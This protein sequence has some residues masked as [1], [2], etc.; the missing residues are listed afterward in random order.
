[1]NHNIYMDYNATAPVLAQA[2]DAVMRAL[3]FVGNPSSVHRMGRLAHRLVED[4]RESVRALVNANGEARVVFTSG[5]TEANAICLLGCGRS[6]IIAS[7]I[8][9]S[10]VRNVKENIELI[11]VDE[12]GIVDI[13]HLE[14]L[15]S[16][17]GE[18]TIVS[19]MLANNETGAI[20]PVKEIAAIAHKNGALFHCDAVQAAGKIE[21]DFDDIGADY[22]SISA[23]KF[24]GP[25]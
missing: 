8:E 4:S 10:A 20:Q 9:H 17:N 18:D 19:V 3:D 22:M 14:K 6:R 16:K 7:S 15:L 1:M 2:K 24:G 12:N 11:S 5:G 23:H 13:S 25:K 21:I